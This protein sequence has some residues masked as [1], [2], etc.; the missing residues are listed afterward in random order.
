MLS[1]QEHICN[2]LAKLPLTSD[3]QQDNLQAPPPPALKK[4]TMQVFNCSKQISF[5]SYMY[6]IFLVKVIELLTETDRFCYI[7]LFSVS[8]IRASIFF[9][10][11]QSL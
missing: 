3:Q 9:F 2:L 4:K 1:T 11:T 5:R 6:L 7:F 8:C 10:K